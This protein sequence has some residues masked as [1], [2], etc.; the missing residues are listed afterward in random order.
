MWAKGE[1]R[2]HKKYLGNVVQYLQERNSKGN[3][4]IFTMS[5]STVEDILEVISLKDF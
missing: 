4:R 1:D 2:K 5:D 3:S